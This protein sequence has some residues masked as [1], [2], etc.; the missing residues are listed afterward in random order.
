MNLEKELLAAKA[1]RLHGIEGANESALLVGMTNTL[2]MLLVHLDDSDDKKIQRLHEAGLNT[3]VD[4]SPSSGRAVIYDKTIGLIAALEITDG[5]CID[6][7]IEGLHVPMWM[8]GSEIK[9]IFG[10]KP[11]Y[12][13]VRAIMLRE[14]KSAYEKLMSSLKSQD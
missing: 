14:H 10:G 11:P 12:E 6:T 5:K 13:E 2:S 7:S 9:S 1:I 8:Q 4:F 3:L